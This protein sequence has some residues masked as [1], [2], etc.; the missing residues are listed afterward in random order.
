[1][2]S[3]RLFPRSIRARLALAFLLASLVPM[4]L[5]AY[6]ILQGS[7]SSVQQSEYAKLQLLAESTAAQLDQLLVDNKYAVL[8]IAGNT[9]IVNLFDDDLRAS[10][11]ELQALFDQLQNTEAKDKSTLAGQRL[12]ELFGAN[13]RYLDASATLQKILESNPNYEYVYLLDGNGM[14]IIE[15]RLGSEPTIIG[16]A[17]KDRAYFSEPY[18]NGRD[19]IDPLVG[20]N[21]KRLGFY[22]SSPILNAANQPV[23]VA[24]I[25]MKGEAITDIVNTFTVGERGYAFLV[26][27]DGV[28]VSHPDPNWRKKSFAPLDAATSVRVGQRFVIDGCTSTAC[29]VPSLEIPALADAIKNEVTGQPIE[30]ALPVTQ[31]LQITSFHPT[32]ELGWMVGINESKDE[33]LAPVRRLQ[34]QSIVIVLLVGV[35]VAIMALLLARGVSGPIRTLARSAQRVEQGQPFEPQ[36]LS[37]VVAKGDEVGHL[38]SVFSNMVVALR[39]RM[40]ELRTIYEIGTTISSSVDLDETL[41]Y[42]ITTIKTVVP[43][44]AAEIALYDKSANAMVQHIAAGASVKSGASASYPVDASYIGLLM[45]QRSGILISDTRRFMEAPPPNSP[46]WE[47]TRPLSYLGIPLVY[48]NAVIGTIELFSK[49]PDGFSQDNLR[50]LESIAI[51][52]AV[53]VH[54]AQEVR[55]RESQLKAQISELKIEIDAAKRS[56]QVEEIVSTDFFQDLMQKASIAR[57][58]SRRPIGSGEEPAGDSPSPAPSEPA[59]ESTAG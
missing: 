18:T 1:M 47:S 5:T 33:F 40:A 41:N 26:D 2:K 11:A 52:A 15:R 43:Y 35:G 24:V 4:S 8:Q 16:L 17:L 28:I 9:T 45:K 39:A 46:T 22:F 32:A 56:K 55:Q 13:Q 34:A 38:A 10:Q 14:P 59:S 23:G 49:Q 6:Y 53:V 31:T 50:M 20:R 29:E 54:N 42:I 27:Q 36:E 7:L 3:L 48:N 30:Y 44:D 58:R 21:S 57:N 51:Q 37:G 25:K 19:Y 12:E